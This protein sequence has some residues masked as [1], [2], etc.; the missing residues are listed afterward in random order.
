VPT[1]NGAGGWSWQDQQG[2]GGGTSDDITNESTVSGATVTDALS[3]LNDQLANEATA[4][5]SAVSSEASTRASADESLRSAIDALV[6]P[7]GQSVVVDSSLSI[8]GAAADANATGDAISDLKSAISLCKVETKKYFFS[9]TPEQ[10][11]LDDETGEAITSNYY[12]RSKYAFELP[13]ST[14]EIV[15]KND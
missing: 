5:Q 13:E 3:S 10:G 14:F 7:Q 15:L 11:G 1:A 6:S 9:P 12:M 8:S 2:G 4:R